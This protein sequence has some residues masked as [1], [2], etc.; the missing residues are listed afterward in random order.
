MRL[1]KSFEQGACIMAILATQQEGRP[2]SS[3]TIERR[4]KMSMT[5][6]QKIMRKLVVAGLVKAVSGNNGGFAL[7]KPINQISVLDAVIALD[8]DIESFPDT[9]LFGKVFNNPTE[10]STELANNA[11]TA[12]HRIFDMA[13]NLWRQVLAQVTLQDIIVRVIDCSKLTPQLDWN[14]EAPAEELL[15]QVTEEVKCLKD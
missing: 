10:Q 2:V 1:A 14:S 13:D 6:G 9:G 5:Y 15:K 4:L 12:V 11:D 8:G 7:A 3:R